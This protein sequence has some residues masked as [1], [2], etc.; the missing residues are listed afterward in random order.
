MFVL[1]ALLPSLAALLS[2]A[3]VVPC[4]VAWHVARATRPLEGRSPAG[5]ALALDEALEGEREASELAWE[6]APV[7]MHPAERPAPRRVDRPRTRVLY[8]LGITRVAALVP[9]RIPQWFRDGSS[10]IQGVAGAPRG[11]PQVLGIIEVGS[12]PPSPP[13]ALRPARRAKRKIFDYSVGKR[14]EMEAHQSFQ[15]VND[16]LLL[17]KLHFLQQA[18]TLPAS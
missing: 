13:R 8:P 15:V 12:I 16:M 1:L 7:G 10:S 14:K 5:W 11:P 9:S 2:L 6:A 18:T 3:L 4:L 17:A